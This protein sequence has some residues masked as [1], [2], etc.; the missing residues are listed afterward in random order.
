MT[1]YHHIF[2]SSS[3]RGNIRRWKDVKQSY[4]D[5]GTINEIAVRLARLPTEVCEEI[6]GNMAGLRNR[7]EIVADWY[8]DA[9][10]AKTEKE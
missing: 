10:S 3:G 1:S 5:L 2:S 9:L 8:F 6:S 4:V 7:A